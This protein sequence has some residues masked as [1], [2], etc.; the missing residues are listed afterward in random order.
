VTDV[1]NAGC[2][3][4]QAIEVPNCGQACSLQITA[5]NVS[6]CVGNAVNLNVSFTSNQPN[7]S[8]NVYKDNIKLNPLPLSTDP[9]GFGTYTSMIIGNGSSSMLKIQFIEIGG[10]VDSMLIQTPSCS[11][12]CLISNFVIGATHGS[13]V[14]EV[15]DFDFQPSQIEI[16]KGDTSILCGPA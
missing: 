13:H 1:G 10:C 9:G 2:S 5:V 3:A 4:Q 8:Y 7:T 15:R 12:P 6:G 16:L 14:V 11:G